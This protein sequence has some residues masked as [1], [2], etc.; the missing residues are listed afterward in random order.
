MRRAATVAAGAEADPCLSRRGLGEMRKYKARFDCEA[1]GSFRVDFPRKADAFGGCARD[2][3][4]VSAL[5][6]ICV[7]APDDCLAGLGGLL[8]S[9]QVTPDWLGFRQSRR[10]FHLNATAPGAGG[11]HSKMRL[12]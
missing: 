2:K 3:Q 7:A 11:N 4:A 10:A 1:L 12:R 8:V 6:Q 5:Q 9:D